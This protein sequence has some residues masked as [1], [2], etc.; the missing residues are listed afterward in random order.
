V[1][2]PVTLNRTVMSGV[3]LL[4]WSVT[5]AVTQCCESTTF[6]AGSGVRVRFAG[7][8]TP[9]QCFSAVADWSRPVSS[10]KLAVMMSSPAPLDPVYVNVTSPLASVTQ[11]AGTHVPVAPAFWPVTANVTTFPASGAPF[12]SVTWAVTV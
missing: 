5:V 9:V 2:E 4:A 8:P 3:G 6:V 11:P 10:V 1:T 12:V 7:G